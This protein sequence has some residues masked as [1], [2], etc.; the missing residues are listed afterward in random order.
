M[1]KFNQNIG[2]SELNKI[3]NFSDKE[4]DLFNDRFSYLKL[5]VGEKFN[6]IGENIPGVFLIEEG[7]MRMLGLDKNKEIFTIEKFSK[8]Q[9]VGAQQL[10]SGI[11]EVCIAASSNVKGIFIPSDIFLNFIKNKNVKEYFS[12]LTLNELFF[13]ISENK[14]SKSLN[15]YD[16]LETCKNYLKKNTKDNI[17]VKQFEIGEN[18]LDES[19]EFW[20][21]SS[22]NID[23][24][25]AGSL[26]KSPS[27]IK[28][29]GEIPGRI[30]PLKN[31][32]LLENLKN[33]NTRENKNDYE[34]YSNFKSSKIKKR[35][36]ALEDRFGRLNKNIS[37]PHSSGKGSL[38]E[39]LACLRMLSQ[40]FDLPFRKDLLKRVIGEQLRTSKTDNISIFKIAALC[41]LLGLRSTILKPDSSELSERIPLPS[42]ILV[43]DHPVIIWEQKAGR[44][45]LSDPIEGQSW[46]KAKKLFNEEFCK[47]LQILF[48]EHTVNSPK[49]RFGLS[50]FL[51]ALNK[52]RNSLIQVVFA[53]FFV[54]LLG[55][56]N[57]LLIQQIIDAV[58]SQ[59]NL[60]SLN[61]LGLLLIAM[62][63]AQAII[64]SLRTYLFTDTTN[65]MDISLG[66]SIIHHL[67]RLPI[68]YFS[69]RPVGEV[70][71]RLNEL[72]KIRNFLTGSTLTIL[73]DSVFSVIYICVMLTYSVRLTFFALAVLPFFIILT[74]SVSPVIRNQLREKAISNARV[75]SHLVETLTGMETVKGQGMELQ[76]EW[77]WEKFYGS[78]IQAG[79]KNTITS[80][81]AGSVSNFLQQLS[82]LIVIWAG[83]LIVLDGKM[84][85]G[86]LIA[87]R[88]LS[89]YVTSP[90]LR[91][92]SLWQN[93][94]ET[95]I[96]LERLS[97]IVDQKEEIEI[98]GTDLPPIAPIEGKIK[99]EKV[100]FS[101]NNKPP[102]QLLNINFEI[103]EGSFIGVVGTSGSGKSTLLKLLTRLYNPKEGFI[104]IDGQDISKI[105]LYSLRSQ[106]GLVPQDCFLFDGSIEE[107]I[108]LT[109]PEASIEEIKNAAKIACAHDFIEEMNEGYSSSV[110]ERGSNLSGG[111]RQR[112]A[113]ARMTLMQPNLLILDE[114]TSALDI[115]TE[116]KVIQNLRNNFK[117]KTVFF[118]SHRLSSLT[119]CDQILVLHQGVL[120]E[121][122]THRELINLNGRYAELYRQQGLEI[123]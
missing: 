50:W 84:S 92:A 89:G 86:Q 116:I 28:V 58:I 93:F 30:I 87:F 100:N 38:E 18:F 48:V 113:I 106:I 3:F 9:L 34:I 21:V 51:P 31:S 12:Q 67:L 19:S 4:A 97:D 72:E 40:N 60:K 80:T 91:L 59:G 90:L 2:R 74:L 70:S 103:I 14:K 45:F 112:I 122:G 69:S 119:F 77:Q 33:K 96:S 82:G 62:A 114:A 101:F 52:H 78:Q 5:E 56:F 98:S 75:N 26:I 43:N 123:N 105:D 95:I 53:T 17:K 83:A 47:N 36:D 54:Q 76:S 85:L 79:F 25:P 120:E 35:K 61:V 42:L 32:D 66:A 108:A 63:L 65:R 102:L 1:V 88:I 24:F 6:K 99:Y 104:Y 11:N 39:I 49:A 115:D 107:N 23:Q 13:A 71:S 57:P 22:S 68:N 73:L 55:L 111:Q 27:K 7:E 121:K 46:I 110:G 64:G 15:S 29:I 37:Y 8:K 117:G 94:Q 118:I 10:L 44:I 41:E 16:V 20:L 109:K 81:A